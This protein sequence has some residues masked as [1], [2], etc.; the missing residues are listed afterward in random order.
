MRAWPQAR[1]ILESLHVRGMPAG[2]S[3]R[4]R[5]HMLNTMLNL[6]NEQQLCAAGALLAIL[7]KEGLLGYGGAACPMVSCCSLHGARSALQL[8]PSW[9]M[10]RELH[11]LRARQAFASMPPTLHS[12]S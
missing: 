10:C 7:N 8:W 6:S 2:L 11:S 1:T 5:A 3:G 4:E 12:A 9:P